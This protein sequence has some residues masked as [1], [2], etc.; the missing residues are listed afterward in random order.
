MV[1]DLALVLRF[2]QLFVCLKSNL[3]QES[4]VIL[5]GR[6]CTSNSIRI[7]KALTS[8]QSPKQGYLQLKQSCGDSNV[9]GGTSSA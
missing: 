5:L 4:I 3:F 2:L 1:S 9:L 7:S 8:D 6:F